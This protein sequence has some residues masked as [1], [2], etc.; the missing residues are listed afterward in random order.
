MRLVPSRLSTTDAGFFDEKIVGFDGL[1]ADEGIRRNTSLEKLATLDALRLG[2]RLTAA[3][4]S[5]ISDGASALLLTPR[6]LSRTEKPRTAAVRNGAHELRPSH[7]L[8]AV[9]DDRMMYAEEFSESGAQHHQVPGARH[10]A[11]PV[12]RAASLPHADP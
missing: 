2:S 7:P 5:Q 1:A 4:S 6:K 8:H 3:V 12:R 10:R 11:D 9:L